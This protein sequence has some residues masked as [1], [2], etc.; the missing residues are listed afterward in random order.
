[1]QRVTEKVLSEFVQLVDNVSH[2]DPPQDIKIERLVIDDQ[3]IL[4]HSVT[5]FR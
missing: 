3:N 2:G 5:P 1:M 4:R